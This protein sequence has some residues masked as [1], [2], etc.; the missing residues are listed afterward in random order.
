MRGWREGLRAGGRRRGPGVGLRGAPD[1][2]RRGPRPGPPGGFWSR[3]DIARCRTVQSGVSCYLQTANVSQPDITRCHAV[4]TYPIVTFRGPPDLS[5]WAVKSFLCPLFILYDNP[6][7]NMQG[8]MKMTSPPMATDLRPPL[9]ELRAPAAG[10]RW[11]RARRGRPAAGADG[12]P[13]TPA[14]PP[15]VLD[16]RRWI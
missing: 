1:D 5:P 14:G 9:R 6:E 13:R 2:G 10:A 12:G 16:D 8:R 11:P 7:W 3:R 4:L 15:Q